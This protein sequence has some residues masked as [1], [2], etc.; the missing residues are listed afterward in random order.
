M[1]FI[2]KMDRTGADYYNVVEMMKE[3]LGAHPVPIQIP[4]WDS[5]D[6]E[7]FLGVIDLLEMKAYHYM[8]ETLGAEY[9]IEEIPEHHREEA[10]K[11]HHDLVEA[12]AEYDDALMEKYLEEEEISTDELK[13]VIRKAT[14]NVK[15]CPVLCGTAFKNKGVQPLL[16][17][18]IDYMPAPIDLPPVKG[19]SVDGEEKLTRKP[20]EDAPFSGLV[21]KIMNDPYVGSLSFVR[22]YS[23]TLSQG[24][25]VLN[26]SK[27]KKTKVGRLMRMHAAKREDIDHI[28]AGD[29]GAVVGLKI[30]GTGDTICAP[31]APVILENI[32]FP[33]PVVHVA[34]EPKTKGDQEKLG[35]SMEKLGSEDP[36]FRIRTDEKTGQTIISGMGELH[37]E[38]IVDR[39][40]REFGV[41][42]NVGAPQVTY[43]ETITVPSEA[44][45]KFVRQSGGRGQYGHV[46]IEI[47]PIPGNKGFTFLDKIKG[48]AIPREYIRSVEQGVKEAMEGGILAGYEMEGIKVSLVDGSYHEVDSSEMAFKVAASMALKEA[49]KKAKPIILEPQMEIEVVLPE[50]YLGDVMGDINGRRGKIEKFEHRLGAQIIKAYVPLAEM[51]G[52]ATDLRSVT[53]GR[54][55]YSMQFHSYAQVP[56]SIQ[57]EILEKASG[58]VAS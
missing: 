15:I 2:N 48:G 16:D 52:Y 42:A 25:E 38:I 53:Q 28:F 13:A 21:F 20:E 6:K 58:Q 24:D 1:A 55:N 37:L 56:A 34:I 54:A 31:N 30:T 50:E 41:Q 19:T 39:L 51:F 26:V 47:E 45:T 11:M 18:V 14:V 22:V 9:R 10:E 7:D 32:Q 57:K 17:A 23:G 40:M 29:I 35:L 5:P 4:L 8:A 3:R 43:R 27:D 12:V 33:E 36:T 49:A 44:D 46:V